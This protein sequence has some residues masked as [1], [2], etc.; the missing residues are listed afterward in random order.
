V[1]HVVGIFGPGGHSSGAALGRSSDT[2]RSKSSAAWK[3]L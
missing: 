3:F 2:N 1:G